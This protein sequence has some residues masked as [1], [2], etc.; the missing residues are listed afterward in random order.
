MDYISI[1]CKIRNSCNNTA[2]S[3][4]FIEL[5]LYLGSAKSKINETKF[6]KHG[7]DVPIDCPL[8]SK[9]HWLDASGTTILHCG[10]GNEKGHPNISIFINVTKDCSFV[11]MNITQNV[12]LRCF[13][14]ES[15]PYIVEVKIISK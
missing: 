10:V 2:L 6:I 1:Y 13:S 15:P 4:L 14:Y 3:F 5:I 7:G 8:A 9:T 12:L 11:V